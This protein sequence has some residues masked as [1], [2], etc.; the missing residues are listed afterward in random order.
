[1]VYVISPNGDE[2]KYN[3]IK[4]D[5]L[6]VELVEKNVKVAQSVVNSVSTNDDPVVITSSNVSVRLDFSNGSLIKYNASKLFWIS[7]V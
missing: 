7:L 5:P 3:A 4:A 1:M 2:F 6:V